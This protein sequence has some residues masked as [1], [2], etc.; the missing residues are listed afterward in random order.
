VHTH[1][2][3]WFAIQ[4]WKS[5]SANPE[6]PAYRKNQAKPKDEKQTQLRKTRDSAEKAWAKLAIGANAKLLFFLSPKNPS[7]SR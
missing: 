1:A 2:N 4:S 5:P 3:T 7:R 6:N